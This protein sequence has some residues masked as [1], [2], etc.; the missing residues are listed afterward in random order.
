MECFSKVI[1]LKNE[2]TYL[3]LARMYEN[4]WGIEKDIKTALKFYI[5]SSDK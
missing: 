1:D 4:G 3:Y 5:L 2:D